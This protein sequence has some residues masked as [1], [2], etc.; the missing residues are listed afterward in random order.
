MVFN[1]IG[2]LETFRPFSDEDYRAWFSNNRYAPPVDIF[3]S[4]PNTSYLQVL[5]HDI[6]LLVQTRG[7][8]LSILVKKGFCWDN[9]SVPKLLRSVVDNDER[10]ILAGALVHDILYLTKYL[11]NSRRDSKLADKIMYDIM[12][13]QGGSHINARTYLGLSLGG[14]HTYKDQSDFDRYMADNYIIIKE[15]NQ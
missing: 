7:I 3:Q 11:G 6:V 5:L 2:Y 15:T 12:Q 8:S 10:G 9:A 4:H 13:E 14:Y 1:K